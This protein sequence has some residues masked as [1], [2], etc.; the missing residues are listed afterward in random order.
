SDV[1]VNIDLQQ[2]RGVVI[3]GN[4]IWQGYDHGLVMN[5]CSNVLVGANLFDSNPNY[6]PGRTASNGLLVQNCE[7]C[8]FNGM[9]VFGVKDIAG[10]NIRDSRRMNIGNC[11]ILDCDNIGLLLEN[12][13]HSK[14][15]GCLISNEQAEA[16]IPVKKSGGK[17]NVIQE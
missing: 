11:T 5:G 3:T 16:F 17:G 6:T 7:D 12:I 14:V 2:C 4:T 13:S 1:M 9:Q 8:T 15:S 10:I